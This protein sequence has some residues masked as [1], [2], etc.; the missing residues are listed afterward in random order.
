MDIP[1]PRQI[2]GRPSYDQTRALLDELEA[3]PH[4]ARGRMRGPDCRR[5]SDNLWRQLSQRL[6]NLDGC[7]KS[8][9]QWQKVSTKCVYRF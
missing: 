1:H 3:H 9:K 2:G 7:T 6:N 5:R 4:L 8:H